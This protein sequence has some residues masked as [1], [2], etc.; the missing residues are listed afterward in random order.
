M[1]VNIDSL[2]RDIHVQIDRMPKVFR[3]SGTIIRGYCY[4]KNK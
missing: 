4:K 3:R 2:K 1:G